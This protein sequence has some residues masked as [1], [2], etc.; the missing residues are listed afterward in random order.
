MRSRRPGDDGAT[1][2]PEDRRRSRALVV[3]R[4]R[5]VRREPYDLT[6]GDLAGRVYRLAGCAGSRFDPDDWF[7]VTRDVAK[8][9]DQAAHAI[10]VCARCAR[11]AWNSR[12]GM[13]SA[14]A[15]TECGPGRAGRPVLLLGEPTR[16]LDAATADA[17]LHA[18]LER[19]ADR[20]LRWITHRPEE[21]ASLP[22]VRHLSADLLSA[23]DRPPD[24]WLR[25]AV[26]EPAA[27][28][29]GSP[30][31]RGASVA[32]PGGVPGRWQPISMPQL[33]ARPPG[34]LPSRLAPPRT[35]HLW[36]ASQDPLPLSFDT[37]PGRR[38][39]HPRMVSCP[40]RVRPRA[41]P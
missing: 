29:V 27:C 15:R 3:S 26:L 20:S 7:P 31:Q 5:H 39:P 6:D 22:E 24:C 41:P 21:L 30:G 38:R 2:W 16:H 33:R 4:A 9:R 18:V 1:S 14:S 34:R 40:C 11:I 35:R 19:A 37:R 23:S 28:R 25:G 17:V 10:A 32:C 12:C 36:R 8:A 13:R